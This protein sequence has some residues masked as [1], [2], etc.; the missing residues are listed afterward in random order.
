MPEE[1]RKGRFLTLILLV[2]YQATLITQRLLLS[3][4][5]VSQFSCGIQKDSLIGLATDVEI[6]P[7]TL[8]A[9]PISVII[10]TVILKNIVLATTRAPHPA[11]PARIMTYDTCIL[12][13]LSHIQMRRSLISCSYTSKYSALVTSLRC[14]QYLIISCQ[15]LCTMSMENLVYT[16]IYSL[17]YSYHVLI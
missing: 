16:L 13:R 9:T 7:D 17:C 2:V 12:M 15:T 4:H 8:S 1:A 3:M 6:R 10:F 11:E 14:L 5:I